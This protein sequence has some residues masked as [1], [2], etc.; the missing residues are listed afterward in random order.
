MKG[1]FLWSIVTAVLWGL[2]PIVEKLGLAK[3][4]PVTAMSLRSFTISLILLAFLGFSGQ[5]P[6][7]AQADTRSLLFIMA[8]GVIAGLLAQWTYFLALKQGLASAV[9]PVIGAYPL[10]TMLLAAL[11]LGEPVTLLKAAG[12]LLVV[13]GVVLIKLPV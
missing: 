9:V 12:A 10:V 7:L 1:A 11:L 6:R 3:V 5:L 2:A 13:A 4:E 8:G